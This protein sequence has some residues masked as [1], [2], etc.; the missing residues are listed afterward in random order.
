MNKLK[1]NIQAGK[2]SYLIT[3]IFFFF[4]SFIFSTIANEKTDNLEGKFIEIK[5]LD[6]VSSKNSLLILKIGEEKVFKNLLTFN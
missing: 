3:L 5:I 2:V 4:F 1:K 6:K